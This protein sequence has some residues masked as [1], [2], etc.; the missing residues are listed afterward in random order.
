MACRARI[1]M[2]AILCEYK[3][4]FGSVG[5]LV[6]VGDGTRSGL[7]EIVKSYPHIRGINFDLPHV[8]A[9]APIYDGITHLG[10]DMFQAIPNA[11]A[12]FMKWIMHDWSDESCVKILK[13]CRKAISEET[14]KVII[15]DV[16]LELEDNGLFDDTGLVFDLVIIA[17]TSGG[18][19]RA[20]LE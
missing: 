10:G 15:V 5:S 8:V 6:D 17:H 4:G 19:E 16:V 2:H 9:T 1:T 12:V 11:D 3:D 13:N 18:K 7:A 14:G 20:E